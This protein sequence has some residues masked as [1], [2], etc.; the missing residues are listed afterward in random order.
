VNDKEFEAAKAFEN[1]TLMT[2]SSLDDEETC[3]VF[4]P[5]DEWPK[6]FRFYKLYR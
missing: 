6:P 2:E 1:W 3:M 4:C 5:R